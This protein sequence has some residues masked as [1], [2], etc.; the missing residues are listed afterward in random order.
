MLTFLKTYLEVIEQLDELETED[1][2][3]GKLVYSPIDIKG[4]EYGN[5]PSTQITTFGDAEKITLIRQVNTVCTV[6]P[7]WTNWI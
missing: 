4:T 7:K 5:D 6:R 1:A 2:L 3:N